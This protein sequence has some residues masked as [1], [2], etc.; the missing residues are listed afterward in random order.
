M[1][2]VP[3]GLRIL[4][5]GLPDAPA[6]SIVALVL[7][8]LV[9]LGLLSSTF[10]LGHPERAWRALGQWRS[11]WLSREGVAAVATYLPA[12]L[13]FLALVLPG[14]LPGRPVRGASGAGR[15]GD[16]LVHRH[17]LRIAA[18]RAGMEP[19]SG[20]GDLP[21]AGLG[22][23]AVLLAEPSTRSS[24]VIPSGHWPWRSS[25]LRLGAVLKRTYW[26]R[27]DGA[28]APYTIA[29]ALGI[30]GASAIRPLDPPHTQPNF[31]MREMGYAVAR[32]HAARLRSWVM[33]LLFAA[34]LGA[35]R[36]RSSRRWRALIL[37]LAVLSAAAGVWV[38]RWL[39]FAEARHVSMLYYGATLG[40]VEAPA[41]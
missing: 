21:R 3:A 40:G 17:D 20:A 25:R 5:A 37:T 7:G 15:R 11:S 31:V 33:V 24:A 35:I 6:A 34:P 2:L 1:A 36:S 30:P 39:F 8:V 27:I 14:G 13:L 28:P 41:Q 4:F 26:R 29:Q 16:G 12:G 18:H 23:G 32:K 9:S 19:R 22:N 10:H 38:E